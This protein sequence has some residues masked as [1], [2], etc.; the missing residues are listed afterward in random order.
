MTIRTDIPDLS[1]YRG[2]VAIDPETVGLDPHR[3]RLCVLQLSPG[4]RRP[5]WLKR[6]ELSEGVT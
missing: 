3:D 1:R 4:D 5:T 2:V 6:G